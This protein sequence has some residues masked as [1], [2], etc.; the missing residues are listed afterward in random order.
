MAVYRGILQAGRIVHCVQLAQHSLDAARRRIAVAKR[1]QGDPDDDPAEEASA[2][3]AV[4]AT[5]NLPANKT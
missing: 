2:T 3:E 4:V 5:V 1:R